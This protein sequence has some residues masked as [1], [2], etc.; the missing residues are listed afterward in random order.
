V[1]TLF[2]SDYICQSAAENQINVEVPIETFSRG[3]KSSPVGGE[4]MIRLTKKDNMA[5]LALSTSVGVS[6]PLDLAD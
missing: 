5:F 3:L 2:E 1:E 4:T 6:L